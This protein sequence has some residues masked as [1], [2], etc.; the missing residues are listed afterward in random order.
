[1][2][3]A[4][5]TSTRADALQTY[6]RA[7]AE[8]YEDASCRKALKQAAGTVSEDWLM[9]S[10]SAC[11]EAYC[12]HLSPD[13]KACKPGAVQGADTIDQAW[14]EL[15]HAILRRKGERR[16]GGIVFG[17]ARFFADL[18]SHMPPRRGVHGP[19]P[20]AVEHCEY[21][22]E[23]AA[24]LPSRRERLNVYYRE[25]APVYELECRTAFTSASR[26]VPEA[27]QAMV[28]L[29]CRKTYCPWFSG[30]S[31]EACD[32]EF[33]P[34][35][36]ATARAWPELHR[37]ILNLDAKPYA[38]RLIRVASSFEDGRLKDGERGPAE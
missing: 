36:E 24:S 31:V 29:G 12:P 19:S 28:L 38:A 3:R 27:Q 16:A 30:R 1:M 6:Q 23:H 8:L 37:A 32:G 14:I 13:V 34:T 4:L 17:F 7:C 35:R 18:N 33:V 25:C 5:R 9:G 22:V 15:S 21:E 20:S 11:A 10:M 26:A 2:K